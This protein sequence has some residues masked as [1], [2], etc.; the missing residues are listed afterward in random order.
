MNAQRHAAVLER[1]RDFPLMNATA[2]R[3]LAVLADEENDAAEV[4]AVVRL[5]P[6]LTANCLRLANSARFG[7]VGEIAS[8]RDAATRLGRARLREIVLSASVGPLLARDVPGYGIPA[9]RL[10]THVVAVADA[11]TRLAKRIDGRG[12]EG[13]F[14]CALLHDVGKLVLGEFLAELPREEAG[15]LEAAVVRGVPFDE[16]ERAVVGLDHAEV[17]AR[18]LARWNLPD[19]LVLSVR[20]H[21]RPD[22]LEAPLRAVDLVHVAD[23]LMT[24]AGFGEG[25]DGLA[26]RISPAATERLGLTAVDLEQVTLQ[27]L[28]GVVETMASLGIAGRVTA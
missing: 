17:G 21:H 2:A 4:E 10:W 1:I 23:G 15:E 27:S 26:Y 6:G 7:A 28:E 5:D 9:G 14:T 13:L 25:F 3:I 11:A 24:M 8:I 18:L 16:A 12:E 22:R 20:H 19:A